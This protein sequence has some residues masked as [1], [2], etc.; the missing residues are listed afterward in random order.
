MA[1][2]EVPSR[3]EPALLGEAAG[4]LLDLLTEIPAAAS[5]L[6]SRLHPHTASSLADLVRVMNCYYS[7]LIQGRPEAAHIARSKGLLDR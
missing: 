1:P 6:G 2:H 3:I 5:A 7:N 4:D